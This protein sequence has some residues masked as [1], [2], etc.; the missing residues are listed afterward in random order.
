MRCPTGAAVYNENENENGNENENEN[1]MPP[2]G[3][4]VYNGSV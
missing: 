1:E 4:A 2:L 3:T